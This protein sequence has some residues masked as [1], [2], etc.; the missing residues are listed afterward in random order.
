MNK[1][2]KIIPSLFFASVMTACQQA[3]VSIEPTNTLTPQITSIAT[4]ILTAAPATFPANELSPYYGE[5]QPAKIIIDGK[6]YDSEIGTTRWITEVQPDGS[7]AMII[8]DAFA[9]ITPKEPVT[10]NGDLSLLLR[11]PIPINPTELWYIVYKVSED[12]L[13]SQDLTQDAF[14]WNP[15]Y[16]TQMYIDNASALLSDAQYLN[17]SLEPGI[18]VFEV[19]AAWGGK[20]PHTELEADYGFL[21]EVQE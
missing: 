15:D 3:G 2:K 7:T 4:P 13:G 8:G 17:F 18:Y 1:M 10:V 21:L 16:N 20:P 9:I 11:L 6:T 14:R 12:E 19:H 5:P